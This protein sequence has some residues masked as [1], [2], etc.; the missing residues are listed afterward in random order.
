MGRDIEDP[1]REEKVVAR[2]RGIA[3]DLDVDPD[4]VEEVFHVLFEL[5]KREQRDA[6]D[7]G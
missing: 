6:V 7:D 2:V 4:A 3:E 1:A 5:N